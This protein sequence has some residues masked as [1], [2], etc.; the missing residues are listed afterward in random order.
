[1]SGS[2]F[3]SRAGLERSYYCL[4]QKYAG[5]KYREVMRVDVCFRIRY[6]LLYENDD[7]CCCCLLNIL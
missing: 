2:R 6:L 1:M 3:E 4:F 5:G 7:G